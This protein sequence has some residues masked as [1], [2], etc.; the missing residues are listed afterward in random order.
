LSGGPG[1]FGRLPFAFGS[2]DWLLAGL[3]F[4]FAVTRVIFGVAY[5]RNG[6]EVGP[7]E[8]AIAI[9]GSLVSACAL[10]W[11]LRRRTQA[12]PPMTS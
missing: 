9:V 11:L 2:V 1:R 5:G 3:V 6:S 12:S 4:A 10:I 7:A 8:I